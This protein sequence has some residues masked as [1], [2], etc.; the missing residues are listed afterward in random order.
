M[1]DF[2]WTIDFGS[3]FL[4]KEAIALA[5][6]VHTDT[7]FCM[8]HARD[9]T[10]HEETMD[11]QSNIKGVVGKED[12]ELFYR[13]SNGLPV[14]AVKSFF[15]FFARPDEEF[16]NIGV[17][18]EKFAG[19]AAYNPGDMTKRIFFFEIMSD[20]CRMQDI[21]NGAQADNKKSCM[22]IHVELKPSF[23]EREFTP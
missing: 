18:L 2:V 11:I 14:P 5:R 21:A 8:A 20:C 3:A 6:V 4:H 10:G 19:H 23:S 1:M 15:K 9:D 22:F 12:A 13:R 17:V 7:S 16:I